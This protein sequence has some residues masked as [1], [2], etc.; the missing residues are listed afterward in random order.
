L[1]MMK[2]SREYFCIMC[3][4]NASTLGVCRRS[5][6]KISSRWPHSEVRLLRIAQGRVARE[7][8]RD[9]QLRA[10]PQ[11]LDARLVTDLH[12]S[13]GEQRHA[14][15]QIRQFGALAEIQLRAR[16]TELVV[17]V[18]NRRVI[19]FA[20]VTVLRLDDLAELRI[21]LHL[22]RLDLSAAGGRFGV[23]NTGLRRSSRM[24]VLFR[25]RS[26]I[27]LGA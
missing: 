25:W 4:Q 23:V 6:P 19:L 7:T 12:P 15:A 10:G 18:M 11:Q 5:S 24:P 1:L 2:S 17:E 20:D 13:A 21:V 8:G 27:L 14:S 26:V 3:W 22:L 16:R 9:D